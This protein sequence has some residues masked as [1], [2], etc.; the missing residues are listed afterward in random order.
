M[1]QRY[2]YTF[3]PWPAETWG[4]RRATFDLFRLAAGTVDME[5]TE[6]EFDT[7]RSAVGHDGIT[8]REVQR[9]PYHQPEPVCG[10]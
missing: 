8:L 10:H 3:R 4:F 1:Q 9:V 5:F 7:F 2:V 6:A